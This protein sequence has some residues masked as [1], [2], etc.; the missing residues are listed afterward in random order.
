MRGSERE[1]VPSIQALY[2]E[3]ETRHER[4]KRKRG[5]NECNEN[6]ANRINQI[7]FCR[8]REEPNLRKTESEYPGEGGGKKKAQNS[9]FLQRSTSASE[10]VALSPGER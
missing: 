8:S 1:L 9:P 3:R 10:P 5:E 2:D 7:F 6:L 4:R